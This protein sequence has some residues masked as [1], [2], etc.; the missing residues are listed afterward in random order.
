LFQQNFSDLIKSQILFPT[1]DLI[2]ITGVTVTLSGLGT[3]IC[4]SNGAVSSITFTRTGGNQPNIKII[5]MLQ[6]GS[7]NLV[8]NSGLLI[9]MESI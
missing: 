7:S 8:I 6:G 5:N 2:S 1:Q 9:S 4:D 3:T